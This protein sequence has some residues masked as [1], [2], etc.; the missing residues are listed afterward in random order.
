MTL[1]E[2]TIRFY[3]R[4]LEHAKLYGDDKEAQRYEYYVK[5]YDSMTAD[6]NKE[7]EFNKEY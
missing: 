4:Q 1:K 2:K 3:Q 6:D 5:H 7:D